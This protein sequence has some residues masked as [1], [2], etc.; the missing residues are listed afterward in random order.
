MINHASQALAASQG[1]RFPVVVKANSG[2]SGAG[3]FKFDSPEELRDGVFDLGVDWTALVQE[4]LPARES[5]IT[6]V[7]VLNGEFLY[8]IQITTGFRT[9]ISA[10]RISASAMRRRRLPWRYV[11]WKHRRS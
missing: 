9:S 1:L 2:G 3:I 5:C 8:A 7:E 6:R 11:R 10:R 4:F